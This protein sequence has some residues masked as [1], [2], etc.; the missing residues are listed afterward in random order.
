MLLSLILLLSTCIVSGSATIASQWMSQVPDSRLVSNMSIPGTH[1]T[2]AR[3]YW[4]ATANCQTQSLQ[5]QLEDGIRYVDVRLNATLACF[6]GTADLKLNFQND[7]MEVIQSFLQSQPTEV[8]FMRISQENTAS[9]SFD[10]NVHQVL[11]SYGVGSLISTSTSWKAMTLGQNRGKIIILK[12]YTSSYNSYGINWSNSDITVQD[13]YQGVTI[14]QK[15][16]LILSTLDAAAN[17]TGD[18]MYLNHASFVWMYNP[19]ESVSRIINPWLSNVLSQRQKV[20]I[21][22]MDYECPLLN[23]AIITMNLPVTT[24]ASTNSLPQATLAGS[25]TTAITSTISPPKDSE[26]SGSET[27]AT[28]T[29]GNATSGDETPRDQVSSGLSWKYQSSLASAILLALFLT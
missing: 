24:I 12:D 21:I 2:L 26:T 18:H 11:S 17:D 3:N 6:H 25:I 16:K 8:I 19:P 4:A 5:T 13:T 15:K 1:D 7:V 23:N 9:S 10:G 29:S 14:A 27:S 28:Q 20:G 22:A